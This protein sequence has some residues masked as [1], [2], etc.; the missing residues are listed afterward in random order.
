L[1]VSPLQHSLPKFY[2]LQYPK[3]YSPSP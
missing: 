2:L 1:E 3:N